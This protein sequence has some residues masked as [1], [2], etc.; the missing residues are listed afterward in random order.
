[1]GCS[2]RFQK[3]LFI[4]KGKEIIKDLAFEYQHSVRYY[5]IDSTMK[6]RTW[7]I[8]ITESNTERIAKIG[9]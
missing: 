7:I 8:K 9:M 5:K 1:M 2:F 6:R 3:Q 4:R